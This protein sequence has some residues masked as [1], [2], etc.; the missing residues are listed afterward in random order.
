MGRDAFRCLRVV[1]PRYIF[2][3]TYFFPETETKANRD[4][5]AP[6]SVSSP[7]EWVLLGHAGPPAGLG[8]AFGIS[9]RRRTGAGPTEW[10]STSAITSAGVA[11]TVPWSIGVFSLYSGLSWSI[12][13]YLHPALTFDW[14]TFAMVRLDIV[15]DADIPP[16]LS[17]SAKPTLPVDATIAMTA[18]LAL[19]I[20]QGL[21][22]TG[23]ALIG[24]PRLSAYFW[25]PDPVARRSVYYDPTALWLGLGLGLDYSWD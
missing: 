1:P 4:V 10:D 2:G 15:D 5:D 25:T 12:R 17:A 23:S 16:S 21:S 11:G 24:A 7:A 8:L 6:P 22:L 18:G 19:T 3:A 20:C 14:R 13:H 9:H